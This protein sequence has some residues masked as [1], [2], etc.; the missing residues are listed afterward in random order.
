VPLEE[1]DFWKNFLRT[2]DIDVIGGDCKKVL[3]RYLKLAD[4]DY[5]VRL[6]SDCPNVPPLVI[7]KAVF[8]AIHHEIDYLSNSW[9]GYRTA[10]DGHDV[11]IMSNKA[12]KWLGNN[13]LTDYD[14]EHVTPAIRNYK[15]NLVRGVLINK[16]DMSH[17]KTCIDTADEYFAAVRR[18]ESSSIKRLDAINGGLNV[19]EY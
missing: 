10:I 9:D 11:E 15:S 1:L 7:N 6:T 14:F 13:S 3:D 2:R 18:F 16:E 19:Y 8:T 4:Y 5:I 12:L 17:I